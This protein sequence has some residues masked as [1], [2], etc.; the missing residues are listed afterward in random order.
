MATTTKKKYKKK[1]FK[2]KTILKTYAKPSGDHYR[3]K[4]QKNLF[5]NIL[6]TYSKPSGDHHREKTHTEKHIKNIFQAKR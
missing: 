4:N 3:E 5:K 1:H 2:Q 6:K